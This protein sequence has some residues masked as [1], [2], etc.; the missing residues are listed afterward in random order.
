[1]QHQRD[2]K[3]MQEKLK[4]KINRV[5]PNQNKSIKKYIQKKL[6]NLIH[7]NEIFEIKMNLIFYFKS[8]LK[9]NQ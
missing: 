5:S 7:Y 6:S 3:E 9:L 1:M 2:G 4:I 8:N